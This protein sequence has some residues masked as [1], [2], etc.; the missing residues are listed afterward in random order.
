MTF[1]LTARSNQTSDT[2]L[3]LMEKVDLRLDKREGCPKQADARGLS[4]LDRIQ[5]VRGCMQ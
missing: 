1:Q 4:A 3:S 2:E 5:F